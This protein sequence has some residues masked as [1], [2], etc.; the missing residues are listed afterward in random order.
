MDIEALSPEFS[1]VI[2]DDSGLEKVATG[3]RFTEGPLWDRRSASLLFS[4][5]PADRIYQIRPGGK[6]QIYRTPS[7]KSNGLTWDLDHEL[8]ACEHLGRRV[9]RTLPDGSVVAVADSYQGRRLNSPNDLVLRSDGS[10]YFSDPPYGIQSAEMGAVAEQEQTLNGFYLVPPGASEPVLLAS[11][12]DR[13]NGMA[14]TPD[15]SRLYV[16]DTPRY[17]VRVFDVR[18]DGTVSGGEVFAQFQ[19]EQGE[20]RPDGMKVNREG[21]LFTTGPGGIW[22]LNPGGTVLGRIH[23]P[24][25]QANCAWG[26]SDYQ[27]LYICA[28]TSIYRIRCRI[29]GIIPP[30]A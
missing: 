17:Q 7:G 29:P 16:A 27:S 9:S 10:L 18:T 25:K 28:S 21:H 26:D 12:F 24:E 11:D 19:K 2:A 23:L 30:G 3:F 22:V 20:G 8:L 13:P 4:D 6:T 15:E 5:I 14:F 1:R